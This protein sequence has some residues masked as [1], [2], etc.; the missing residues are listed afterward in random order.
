[1]LMLNSVFG[2]R[3]R[4]LSRIGSRLPVALFIVLL[5][6]DDNV[7]QLPDPEFRA[8]LAFVISSSGFPNQ[9]PSELWVA[10]LDGRVRGLYRQQACLLTSPGISPDGHRVAFRACGEGGIG[11]ICVIDAEGLSFRYLTRT[12]QPEDNP[13]WSPDGSKI[14]FEAQREG[15]WAVC[16]TD[17]DSGGETI[18]ASSASPLSLGNWS[19]DG[20]VLSYGERGE[21]W[22]V[23]LPSLARLQLTAGQ[24]K[25]QSPLW[26]LTDD[27]LAVLGDGCICLVARQ[28]GK[29]RSIV[30][31][32][33]SLTPPLAWS[34]DGEFFLATGWSGG[35]PD[36]LRIMRDGSSVQNLTR[37]LAPGSSPVLL[38]DRRQF[39]YVADL[40]YTRRIFLMET[41]GLGNRILMQE[42][43]DESSPSARRPRLP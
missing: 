7:T 28:G 15:V 23:S 30:V 4:W 19:G 18:V 5:G 10:S 37:V 24:G 14:A 12:L 27:S 39:A 36:I 22:T 13:R 17:P 26:S 32:A 42:S 3:A 33:D 1:M 29:V 43:L 41:D 25:S 8:D 34:F 6:C 20:T 38:P 40:V 9:G 2:K 11:D 21:L 16:V 31:Q 35:R